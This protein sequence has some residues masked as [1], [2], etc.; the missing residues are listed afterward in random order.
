MKKIGLITF[1]LCCFAS[2]S[3]GQTAIPSNPFGLSMDEPRGWFPVD[4][5]EIEESLRKFDLQDKKLEQFLSQNQGHLLLFAYV[6]FKQG[7]FTGMNP[8]V[9]GR[10]VKI[11][12]PKP[13]SFVEFRPAAIAT[14]KRI[15][16]QFEE[17][18]YL[19]EPTDVTVGGIASVFHVSE[20]SLKTQN[21]TAHRVRSRTY[22]IPQGSHFFQLSF[23]D[24]PKE[25]DCSSEFDK[26]ISSVKIE[27]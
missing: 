5:A 23:V 7:S 27:K 4:K 24:E 17:Q 19:I 2:I 6:R 18:L 1:L 22:L 11:N 10:V 14:L 3:Y 26:L 16:S 8:K 20:F 15:A 12:S 9:E 21:G 25:N 13:L